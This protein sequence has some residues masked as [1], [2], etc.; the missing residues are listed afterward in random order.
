MNPVDCLFDLDE[1]T[2]DIPLP[3]TDS[4]R[5]TAQYD[6]AASDDCT[7]IKWEHRSPG[8]LAALQLWAK[9]RRL[10]VHVRDCR[11]AAHCMAYEVEVPPMRHTITVYV[12][13]PRP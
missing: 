9:A 6:A 1:A 4:A 3:I 13:E 12:M 11:D 8:C 2:Q 7:F 5:Y 10:P